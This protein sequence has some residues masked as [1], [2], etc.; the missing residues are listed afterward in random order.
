[1]FKTEC[2]AMRWVAVFD[3]LG[4]TQLLHDDSEW[5]VHDALARAIERARRDCKGDTSLVRPAWFS[6]TFILFTPDDSMQSYAMLDTIATNFFLGL[7]LDHIPARGALACG[8]AYIDLEES[9]IF[10]RGLVEAYRF[11]DAQD[12]IGFIVCPSAV[13]LLSPHGLPSG[14]DYVQSDVPWSANRRPA[15]APPQLPVFVIGRSGSLNGENPF[16]GNLH[17]M[18]SEAAAGPQR[19]KYDRTLAFIEQHDTLIVPTDGA[20]PWRAR[21]Q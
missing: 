17:R 1:M 7:I 14:L 8:R 20:T 12:W 18:S 3:L 6:D 9:V 21:R 15:G 5:Q 19:A 16:I 13:A 10:G 11:G 2:V 4:T